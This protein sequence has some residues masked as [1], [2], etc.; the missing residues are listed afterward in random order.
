MADADMPQTRHEQMR[1]HP[2]LLESMQR[3]FG[4]E[5]LRRLAGPGLGSGWELDA[6]C[7]V[8]W[9]TRVSTYLKAWA[10]SLDPDALL[11]IA[12]LLALAGY[13][14][15]GRQAAAIVAAWF[16]GYA[17]RYFAGS[18]DPK[19][20]AGIT[21]RAR[22]ILVDISKP[23]LR[24][25]GLNVEDTILAIWKLLFSPPLQSHFGSERSLEWT[26]ELITNFAAGNQTAFCSQYHSFIPEVQAAMSRFP[27][28]S[29][30]NPPWSMVSL[31]MRV[32]LIPWVTPAF[33]R[34]LEILLRNGSALEKHFGNV[35][36]L[37]FFLRGGPGD[38]R[39]T[40]FRIC[41]PTNAV[42]ASAEHW[43]MRAYVNRR[44]E[45]PHASLSDEAGRTYSRHDY[46]DGEGTRKELF[47]ETTDSSGR[48][49]EDFQE[50]LH[51]I[52]EMTPSKD[53]FSTDERTSSNAY[54]VQAQ[55]ISPEFFQCWKAAGIHLN[56]QVDMGIQSWLRAHPYPPVL[57]HLSFRLGNQ[58]FFI[59]VEDVDGKVQ[60][61]GTVSELVAIAKIANGH[62]CILPMR[63]NLGEG[64]AASRQGWGL[65][66][67]I[68]KNQIN[69]AA[70][71]TD[72]RVEMTQW[73]LHDMAVQVVRD[74]LKK[75]GFQM[76]SWNG[77]PDVDP[78]IWFIGELKSPEWVVVRSTKFPANRAERPRNWETIAKNCAK[79]STTGHFASVALVSIAQAFV[80]S[81]EEPVPLWRGHGM[82][83]CFTGLE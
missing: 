4:S 60:G 16:P 6:I 49:E 41:A 72:E 54:E 21:E 48:E 2:E 44:E 9:K 51:T 13:N 31:D 63:R 15:E 3:T 35:L 27:V 29:I 73:E 5:A 32:G 42:R 17:P 71:V 33:E 74:Y 70:L 47:F 37:A 34:G 11:E 56:K 18:N 67:A 8:D 28:H 78:S 36:P 80:S 82:H 12:Q 14:S 23:R 38:S 1:F 7:P 43:L 81:D 66:D 39:E 45:G 68:T 19:L 58:L 24:L 59:R 55:Q 62:A 76:M 26:R 64:W 79:L 10:M 20:V 65:L 52:L 30:S 69:P 25:H 50:F 83:V 57:E 22:E 61:P 53:P 46:S 40:A 77:N 75:E